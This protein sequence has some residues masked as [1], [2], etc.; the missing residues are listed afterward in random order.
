MTDDYWNKLLEGNVMGVSEDWLQ[1][2]LDFYQQKGQ[3]F[4]QHLRGVSDRMGDPDTPYSADQ[5]SNDSAK[6][7]TLVREFWM[8]LLQMNLQGWGSGPI[9]SPT[10]DLTFA[11]HHK[12]PIILE[13]MFPTT[14]SEANLTGQLWDAELHDYSIH[15]QFPER[16]RKFLARLQIKNHAGSEHFNI[17]IYTGLIYDK[18]T[19]PVDPVA[20]FRVFVLP[21]PNEGVDTGP[22]PDNRTSPVD[23]A[24]EPPTKAKAR[25]K[26]AP[27]KA[28]ARKKSGAAKKP[29][30]RRSPRY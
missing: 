9:P 19:V 1:D 5:F 7:L 25:R 23:I 13:K 14:V 10:P 8:D 24:I 29:A 2:W 21:A 18:S 4:Q 27:K 15:M 22:G 6:G 3:G 30:R 26:A 28:T 20:S 16:T 11:F 17:G 12:K